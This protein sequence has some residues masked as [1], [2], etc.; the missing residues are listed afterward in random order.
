[1]KRLILGLLVVMLA[2]PAWAASK[3]ECKQQCKA[4]I[5]ACE[6]QA[7]QFAPGFAKSFRRT[8][9]RAVLKAC[10]RGDLSVCAEG[11]T[12]VCASPP[13]PTPATTGY[14][15][16]GDGTI[17][18]LE[19]GLMWEKK[20]DDESIHDK[21][22]EYFWDDA[23][24][25]HVAG[26]NNASFAGYTDWRLPSVKE[27][28]S[29]IDY[30]QLDPAVNSVFHSGCVTG[31]TVTTCSCTRSFFYWS[32]TSGAAGPFNAWYVDFNA[33]LVGA[34]GKPSFLHK[35]RAVRGGS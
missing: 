15:D 30:E 12:L 32:S 23:V 4:A 29:I 22:T 7:G 10:R 5:A 2:A 16:N 33:G 34:I 27:L 20:S 25:V 17:T 35:V 6:D 28:L 26:L 9:K 21:D 11:A 13:P 19:T 24:A 31:C 8:C 3:R 1:M 14:M 18:D